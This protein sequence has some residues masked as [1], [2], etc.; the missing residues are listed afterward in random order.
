MKEE[1]G[2]RCRK[3]QGL[4][5]LKVSLL[6]CLFA[7][8]ILPCTE[9]RV[10]RRA[11]VSSYKP[12]V[13]SS[14]LY[15]SSVY[16]PTTSVKTKPIT[17][18]KYTPINTISYKPSPTI[19]TKPINTISTKPVTTVKTQP[20][21]TVKVQPVSPAL[22]YPTISQLIKP[23]P[24]ISSPQIVT[25]KVNP[26]PAV[27]P[28]PP[29]PPPPIASPIVVSSL[30]RPTYSYLPSVSSYISLPLP[31]GNTVPKP[32]ATVVTTTTR[33]P[34]YYFKCGNDLRPRPV[35]A[36]KPVEECRRTVAGR[37]YAG[38]VIRTRSGQYCEY[39]SYTQ[40]QSYPDINFPDGNKYNAYS[41]C[42]NPDPLFTGGPWCYTRNP[43]LSWEL[44][45][46]PFCPGSPAGGQ[47]VSKPAGP[48]TDPYNICS[49]K[50]CPYG[51]RCEYVGKVNP[52]E[53]RCVC[54]T[55]P[56]PSTSSP[57]CGSN[58]VTYDNECQLM[59]AQCNSKSTIN[60]RHRGKCY[61]ICKSDETGRTYMGNITTTK[62]GKYCQRWSAQYPNYHSFTSGKFFPD[63]DVGLVENR[64]RNPDPASKKSG[65]WC[66]TTGT[67]I[68][69]DWDYCDVPSCSGCD[70]LDIVVALHQSSMLSLQE[71]TEVVNEFGSFLSAF[72]IGQN[73]VRVGLMT[74]GTR[75]SVRFH[76]NQLNSKEEVV[77]EFKKITYSMQ[78]SNMTGALWTAQ[79]MFRADN[80]D[81]PDVQNVLVLLAAERDYVNSYIVTQ[82]V[83]QLQDSG[84]QIYAV[85][86]GYYVHT[87]WLSELATYSSDKKKKLFYLAYDYTQLY[88]T[89][90]NVAIDICRNSPDN[91]KECKRTAG[92]WD[93]AGTISKTKSGL[94]CRNWASQVLDERH[95]YTDSMF[96]DGS[97][98]AAGTKCRNPDREFTAGPWCFTNSPTVPWE[99]CDVKTCAD[100]TKPVVK[101][102]LFSGNGLLD[103]G[104][105][106]LPS[107]GSQVYDP[108][109]GKQ[110]P[111]GSRCERLIKEGPTSTQCVCPTQACPKGLVDP[112]CGSDG[113]TYD[114]EC[115]LMKAQCVQASSSKSAQDR[116]TV[117]HRGKCRCDKADV[118]FVL[119]GS[120][121]ISNSMWT[122]ILDFVK[123]IVSQLNVG[124]SNIRVGVLE[125]GTQASIKFH[126]DSFRT[127]KD[128]LSGIDRIRKSDGGTNTADGFLITRKEMFQE[129]RGDR[130]DVPNILILITDGQSTV[131]T[132]KTIQ[133]A[134]DAK[135]AGITILAVGVQYYT[136]YYTRELEQ[137]A[138][139]VNGVKQVFHINNVYSMGNLHKTIS[140]AVCVQASDPCQDRTCL[141]GAVCKSNPSVGPMSSVNSTQ[142]VCPSTVC[143]YLQQ[144]VC[145]DDGI[146]YE[147]ECHLTATRCTKQ[148]MI[149]IVHR[150]VCPDPCSKKVCT[151]YS[152]CKAVGG[153]AN[154]V[155]PATCPSNVT[156]HVCGSDN[157]TYVTECHLKKTACDNKRDVRLQYQGKCATTQT[158][159]PAEN[160]SNRTEY[161]CKST[162][163]GTEFRGN[164]TSTLSGKP[165]RSWGSQTSFT[166][167]SLYPEGSATLAGNQCRNP[168]PSG[169]K[170]GPWCFTDQSPGSWEYC[171][172]PSCSG[173]ELVDIVFVLDSSVSIGYQYWPK[174]LGFVRDMIKNFHFGDDAAR[175]GVVTYGYE[176][177][178]EFHLNQFSNKEAVLAGVDKIK[179]K[180]ES[181]NTSGAIWTMKEKM[182]RADKGDRS[183]A[184]NICILV[185]DGV[186]N[187]DEELTV[188]YAT[189][190]KQAGVTIFAVGVGSFIDDSELKGMAST[191]KGKE[192]VY[193][194]SDYDSLLN[195]RDEISRAICRGASTV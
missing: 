154:C 150:G 167:S 15:T 185:T 176:S 10:S 67:Y 99:I 131:N 16:R 144:Y 87:T 183:N 71:W 119:D 168:D 20:I 49:K 8:L 104:S 163:A 83:K 45:D 94:A 120:G 44:C 127:K 107:G 7:L 31:V 57:I 118:V 33:K 157:V 1:E 181:T 152:A 12:A 195:I 22:T 105:I 19:Y 39:W 89:L 141:Y 36:T 112:M 65:P 21:S 110:C 125:F 172:V 122:H 123:R 2:R 121:S 182:F 53:T 13:R 80:G 186:S 26:L 82:Q 59:K 128:V 179:Y 103:L 4:I 189:Q 102:Q 51:S 73:N 85:G 194:V 116:I 90:N 62:S 151:H 114:N 48:V 34:T 100:K 170:A 149:N 175:F 70:K 30:V 35:I 115:L 25:T 155:C 32:A 177:S 64:C 54:P 187:M 93:Y 135:K 86:V 47:N 162:I 142:C 159:L 81:R 84:V 9:S 92:G 153:V 63:G 91:D 192:E 117:L 61:D 98:E 69:N 60:V 17:T 180:A 126:L 78:T 3:G 46:I 41:R 95:R 166:H 136:S 24:S 188:P 52:T 88:T 171:D 147:S 158:V 29:P 97:L 109:S 50:T 37:E 160:K 55:L 184:P 77:S 56:C 113:V 169:R 23:L 42:R 66:Y 156:S 40:A 137:V 5:C 124:Q 174:A 6:A 11:S 140:S 106:G 148:R 130:R 72:K 79:Q 173:C 18:V 178:I 165:C 14:S 134:E 191:V 193:Y 96:P 74:H 28:L 138:S 43:K 139:V 108:C 27:K 161:F 68:S 111:Y 132:Q 143:P 76:L 146:T 133:Y 58:G 75:A 164:V 145:G 38:S 101:S 129:R 190:A